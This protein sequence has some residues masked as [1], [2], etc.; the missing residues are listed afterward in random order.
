[1]SRHRDRI[2]VSE[3]RWLPPGLYA[4]LLIALCALTVPELARPLERYLVGSACFLPRWFCSELALPA[5]PTAYQQLQQ[6]EQAELRQRV[7]QLGAEVRGRLREQDLRT[8]AGWVHS[9]F[10]PVW[11]SV[12]ACEPRRGGGGE[13]CEL[14]LDRSF[15][16]LADCSEWVSKGEV[17][18]GTLL[19]PPVQADAEANAAALAAPARVQLLNHPAARAYAAVIELPDAA[20]LRLVVRPAA[21]ADPAPLRVELWDDPY[22]SASL[23]R[24]G[25]AVRTLAIPGVENQPEAGWLLG[26]TR[27]WGYETPT[28]DR[29]MTIGVYVVPPTEPR[30]IS[31]VVVWRPRTAPAL[32]PQAVP[33]RNPARLWPL[34]GHRTGRS[35]VAAAAGVSD[36]AAVLVDGVIVGTA[37]PQAF[38]MA[39]VST[40]AAS[41]Q[42]W[43][44]VLMPEDRTLRTRE[45]VGRFLGIVDGV[46]Q[47]AW[48]G[49]VAAGEGLW[50]PSGLLF[51]GS[52][53]PHCP[54][55]LL[56]GRARP[57]AQHA[58][59][60]EVHLPAPSSLGEV[61]LL[62]GSRGG[63]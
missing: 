27:I 23:E 25:H 7:A 37:Q 39:L 4:L 38:G 2:V 34:P 57:H 15:G 16:E 6:Q 5:G 28:G 20:R 29:L 33:L 43:S 52:N 8:P 26:R 11:C 42:P 63:R 9:Q 62:R 53:G 51:T 48:R 60:I 58:D 41:R 46:L 32:V 49:E 36:G 12:V 47:F 31:H 40:F 10:D 30:A 59:R 56:L 19:R 1:M 45:L 21:I 55:G 44:L 35:L 18:L 17:L 50:L 22:R 3:R 14:V 24:G 61:Q 54:A 13:P